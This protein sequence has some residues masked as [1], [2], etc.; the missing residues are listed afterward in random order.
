LSFFYRN[1]LDARVRRKLSSF[2][3]SFF[4]DV[5]PDHRSSILV[6]GSGRSGTNWLAE[7]INYDQAHRFIVEPFNRERVPLA[8]GFSKMQYLRPDD[9]DPRFVEPARAIFQGRVRCPW[10]DSMNARSIAHSR[11][12]KDVRSSLLSGWI[13]SH[14]PGMP[15]VYIVRHPCAVAHSRTRLNWVPRAAAVYLDQTALMEDHLEPFRDVIEGTYSPFLRHV[16]D[17]CIENYVPMRQLDLARPC[18]VQYEWLAADRVRELRRVFDHIGQPFGIEAVRRS[19]RPSATSFTSPANR[20]HAK[21]DT[22]DLWHEQRP[23]SEIRAAM[24][25]VDRFGLES[26][27]AS[28]DASLTSGEALR[29]F[30]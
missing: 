13:A 17:W 15:L 22:S 10:T 26:W 20:A 21:R 5:N 6:F 2:L 23:R 1:T 7:T 4:V 11:V 25:I 3:H 9:D 28:D 30:R 12:I 14:F 8:A 29:T 19:E 16:V 18:I 24:N 27:F